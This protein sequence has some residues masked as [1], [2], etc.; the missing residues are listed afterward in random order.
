[1]Q[2]LLVGI[3]GSETGSEAARWAAQLALGTGAELVAVT[4][5]QA[6]QA[7]ASPEDFERW[8]AEAQA[9]LDGKLTEP[10]RAVGGQARHL[11][12]HGKPSALLDTAAKEQADLLVIG[13][14][15]DSGFTS[16]HLGAEAHHLAHHSRGPLAIVPAPHHVAEPH[17]FPPVKKIVV[18]VD[19]SEASANA[20]GWVADVA[21]SLGAQVSAIATWDPFVEWVPETDPRSWHQDLERHAEEWIKP[22]R[23]AGVPTDLLIRRE[24]HPSEALL[25]AAADAQLIVVGIHGLSPITGARYGGTAIQVLNQT[26]IPVAMIPPGGHLGHR[27]ARQGAETVSSA[28]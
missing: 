10:I 16:L 17:R 13:T 19:G 15:G 18:C 25:D 26:K 7:E 2:K 6:P 28:S 8:Q 4:A 14:H 12:V 27:V 11:L 24:V 3:D 1:M 20:V 21:G 23:D 5:W 22:L 9:R